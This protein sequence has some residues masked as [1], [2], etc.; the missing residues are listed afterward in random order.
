MMSRHNKMTKFYAI[1][2]SSKSLA[3]DLV[4]GS[5]FV[6]VNYITDRA[7]REMVVCKISVSL[8]W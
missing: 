5:Y 4:L 6:T 1:I 7:R 8:C 2:Y 3:H